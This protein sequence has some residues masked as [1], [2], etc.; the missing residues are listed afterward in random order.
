MT[1]YSLTQD[2]N[3]FKEAGSRN[4]ISAILSFVRLRVLSYVTNTYM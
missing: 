1:E 2:K 4:I 3:L